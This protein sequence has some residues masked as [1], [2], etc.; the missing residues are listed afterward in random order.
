MYLAPGS[1]MT[2]AEILKKEILQQYR[3]VRQFAMEMN[4]P[5]STLVT[6]LERGIEG[7]AYISCPPRGPHEQT[8]RRK[9][10]RRRSDNHIS[11]VVLLSLCPV[12]RAGAEPANLE[13]QALSLVGRD[14]YEKLVKGYTEK[15]WGR[16]CRIRV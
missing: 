9:A 4:I 7:M 10:P 5:Y 8:P 3:S 13:E 14:V 1:E 6:A 15:Q 11:F 2:K 12:G 16:S